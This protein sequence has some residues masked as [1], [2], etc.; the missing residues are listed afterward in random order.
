VTL[1]T[2]AS[3]LALA[4]TFAIGVAACA[5]PPPTDADYVT[6]IE[7][8]RQAKDES[9][10][11]KDDLIPANR[12]ADFLPLLYYPVSPSYEVPAELKPSADAPVLD[13]LTSTGE[14]RKMRRV[15]QLEFLVNGQPLKL[16]AFVEV[17]E[18]LS[19]LFVPFKDLTNG[20]D[21]YEA[22]RYLELPRTA[23]GLYNLD[24]NIAFTPNCHFSPMFSCP[25]PPKENNLP[26]E[27]QA[28]EKVRKHS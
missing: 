17:G 12:K 22:G 15:G 25:V 28:G 7:R 11:R 10:Q 8:W 23:T 14:M 26:V 24:F 18:D 21:T 4:V 2:R 9:L 1:P 20:V 3:V 6:K 16:T 5:T 13:M 27:I 19:R